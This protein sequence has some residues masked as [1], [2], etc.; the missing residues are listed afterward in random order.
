MTCDRMRRGSGHVVPRL[1]F[2]MDNKPR[3]SSLTIP[4]ELIMVEL[5]IVVNFSQLMCC[6]NEKRNE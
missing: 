4:Q 1:V 2:E 3:L 5:N 6:K